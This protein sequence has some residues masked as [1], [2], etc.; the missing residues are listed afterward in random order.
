M[1]TFTGDPFKDGIEA[2]QRYES[3]AIIAMANGKITHLGPASRVKS[4][5]P[6]GTK[7]TA[8]GKDT[9]MVAGF[10]DS[11]VHFPQ[12]PMIAAQRRATARLAEQVHLPD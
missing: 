12:T 11:H 6:P 2:T 5:L 1:L 8:N 4:K 3:D 9:L 7:V 10:I